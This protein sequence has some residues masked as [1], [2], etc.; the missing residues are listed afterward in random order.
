MDTSFILHIL[1][2]SIVSGLIHGYTGLGFGLVSMTALAFST[3][4]LERMSVGVSL[5]IIALVIFLITLS[6]RRSGV[7]WK[8]VLLIG[9][10]QVVGIPVGYRFLLE[11]YAHPVLRI[12]LGAV[13]LFAALTALF[14]LRLKKLKMWLAP[15]FGLAGGLLAGAFAAG[16]P[17]VALYLYSQDD[18][19]RNMKCTLQVSFVVA[20]VLRLIVVGMGRVG[21]TREV[22]GYAAVAV[23]PSLAALWAA[24]LLSG[25]IAPPLLKKSIFASIGFFGLLILTRG[26]LKL[27]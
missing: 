18:D 27:W 16:G 19:P 2:I 22:F 14:S 5:I 21:Y 13:I 11:L 3:Y 23:V 24:H 9:A 6:Y 4:N 17:I 1:L 26:I 15:L 10:G 20:T 7:F 8:Y 25:K 12:S